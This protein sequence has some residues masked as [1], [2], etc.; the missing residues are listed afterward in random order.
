M[1][2]Y[3]LGTR[4]WHLSSCLT[5]PEER[6]FGHKTTDLDTMFTSHWEY[7]SEDIIYLEKVMFP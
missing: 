4:Y 6:S 5:W 3:C 7:V 2:G 1:S